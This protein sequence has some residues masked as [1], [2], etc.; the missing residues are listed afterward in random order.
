[1]D[2]FRKTISV[3][4]MALMLA[5]SVV[6]AAP[7]HASATKVQVSASTPVAAAATALSTESSPACYGDYCSGMDPVAS[8][9][10][11]GAVTLDSHVQGL[12]G[13]IV[14]LRYSA[15]CGT[16]WARWTAYPTGWCMNCG[17]VGL[18]AVQD[19]GYTQSIDLTNTEIGDGESVWSPMIYSPVK[20][21]KAEII[22]ICGSAGMVA[23]A[24]DCATNGVESTRSL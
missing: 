14:E 9:C 4:A 20:K 23:S 19:T 6:F 16:N 22:N 17:I 11:E 21:V 2:T 1:M 12:G 10:S 15:K 18:R 5:L 7:G 24:F 8:G 13:G 3:G